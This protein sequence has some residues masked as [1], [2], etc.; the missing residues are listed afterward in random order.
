MRFLN[1][2]GLF[3]TIRFP[4]L[5]AI[6]WRRHFSSP[7]GGE[8]GSKDPLTFIVFRLDAMGDVVLTTALLRAI[9]TGYPDCRLTV[10]VQPAYKSLLAANPHIDEILTLPHA[11]KWLPL[12]LQRLLA[13]ALFARQHLRNRYFD[14]AISPRWDAD[15]HHATLLCVRANAAHRVGYTCQ[16]SAAKWRL[17]RGFDAAFDVCLPA[18]AVRHEVLRSLAVAEALGL[19]AGDGRPE[20]HITDRDR[21][22]AAALLRRTNAASTLVALGI[23]AQSPGRRW[24]LVNYAE[25]ISQ[26]AARRHVQPVIVCSGDEMGEALHLRDLLTQPCIIVSG[27]PLREVCAVLERCALFIGNDS[28]CAHL[29]AAA[30]CRTIVVSRHPGD[31][32]PNHRNS[33]L[34]FSPQGSHVRVLQPANGKDECRTGCGRPEPHCITQISSVGVTAAATEMLDAGR[35]ADRGHLMLPPNRLR[36]L[37]AAHSPEAIRRVLDSLRSGGFTQP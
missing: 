34:R 30:G 24:P 20:I 22:Q 4:T 25:V 14:Y 19:P 9:K 7:A 12:R 26:L 18:G 16:T 1:L 28:G 5:L 15:E 2:L 32:D 8:S 3:L 13:A 36:Q 17:N 37:A 27:A 6:F 35:A 23:G 10:V 29:A 31:G 11:P 21:R 33:P